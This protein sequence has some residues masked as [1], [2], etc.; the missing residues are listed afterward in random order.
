MTCNS[1]KKNRYNGNG[2]VFKIQRFA[3]QDGPGMRTTVFLKGCP[4]TCGWCANPESQKITPEIMT[5]DILCIGCGKCEKICPEKAISIINVPA[6]KSYDQPLNKGLA[7]NVE[8]NIKKNI[9]RNIDWQKCNQ[10]MK[11]VDVCPARAIVASG[12][13]KSVE[14]VMDKVIKDIGFYRKSKGGMTVSGGEPLAQCEFTRDL[15]MEASAKGIH[16]ALDTTGFA[17]W[18][19]LEKLLKYVDLFLYDIKNID[20]L[21]HKRGTGVENRLIFEN[22]KRILKQKKVWIRRAVIPGFNDSEEEIK[23]FAHFIAGL[24]PLPDKISLLPYH[25]FAEAKYNSTGRDYSFKNISPLSEE[26]IDEIKKTVESICD[27]NVEIGK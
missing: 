25:K 3:I 10:C 12:E 21:K 15:L 5:R 1:I 27:V 22:L 9:V 18:E 24:D 7:K 13:E 4:L 8:N 17:R 23:K 14:E 6:E 11:C 2:I 20:S 16:T 19:S 26:R